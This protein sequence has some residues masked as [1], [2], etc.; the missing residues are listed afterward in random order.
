MNEEYMRFKHTVHVL[1]DNFRVTYKLLVYI[2]VVLIITAGVSAAIIIPF[3]DRLSGVAAYEGLTGAFS[4]MF[5][6]ILRGNLTNLSGYFE[7]IRTSFTDLMAYLGEHPTDLAL[8]AAGLALT[9]L[10]SDFF[11]GLG[12]C[13]ACC[14][15]NDKMAMHANSPFIATLIKNLGKAALYSVIY[16]PISFVYTSVCLVVLYLILFVALN[17]VWLLIQLFLFV[18]FMMLLVGLKMTFIS[19]WLPAIICGKKSVTEGFRYSFTLKSGRPVSTFSFYASSCVLILSVNVLACV[20]T[21]GAGL[22]ITVPMSF[23]YL[24]CYQL[25][26]YCDN[27]DIKY[28]TD[29]RSI[30]KPER[31]KE[32]SREQF[33]RGE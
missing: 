13:A 26:N 15:V 21:F 2:L 30:V 11:I 5:R 33:L 7:A 3:L 10:V 27:N 9:M 25:V 14:V 23:L 6:E 24:I 22:I 17:G 1:I 8:S 12:N 32:T 20:S 28:F 31:E 18:V 4:E 19:D 29:K 16:V